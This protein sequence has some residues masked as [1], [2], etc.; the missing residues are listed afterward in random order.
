MSGLMRDIEQDI[1]GQ[2]NNQGGN[3]GYDNQQ[4]GMGGQGGGYEPSLGPQGAGVTKPG[5]K[6][7][8]GLKLLG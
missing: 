7:K 4:G 3:S 6:T 8:N 1:S 5:Q 2:G